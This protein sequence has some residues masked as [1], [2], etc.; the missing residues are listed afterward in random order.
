MARPQLPDWRARTLRW[1]VRAAWLPPVW[2]RLA[3][4]GAVV[5]GWIACA[6]WGAWL[7]GGAPGHGDAGQLRLLDLVYVPFTYLVPQTEYRFADRLLWQEAVARVLGAAVP[8]LGLF[9]LVRR[10]LLGAVAAMLGAGGARGYALVLGNAGS[11][12]A[13]AMATSQAG[14]PVLLCDPSIADD[15]DRQAAL[16]GAGVLTLAATGSCPGRAGSITAWFDADAANLAQALAWQHDPGLA[17]RDAL[18]AVHTPAA[19]RAM[20]AAP[21][22]AQRGPVRLRP[23][24]VEANAVRRSLATAD[25]VALA[26]AR[27]QSR[28]TLVLWGDG[29]SLDWA[30]ECALRQFWSIHLG[31]PA[32][33]WS[34]QGGSAALAGLERHAPGVFE[35]DWQ[36]QLHMDGDQPDATLHWVDFHSADTTIRT[37]F[38]LAARLAQAGSDPAPVQPVL[39]GGHAIEPLFAGGMLAFL[40]PVLPEADLTVEGL[41]SRALDEAAALLHLAYEQRHGGSGSDSAVTWQELPEIYVAANR[42][43]ADHVAVKRWDAARSALQGEAL[44]DALARVEHRRWC[45]ERLLSGWAPAGPPQPRDNARRL[46]PDLVPWSALSEAQ[47][48]KDREQVREATGL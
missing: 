25:P 27:G 26:V 1:L 20:L 2:Q 19:Q 46:H 37:A 24:S 18:F 13:L 43:A 6:V 39:R 48:E 38:E 34:G 21:L 35:P 9:W 31:P 30:A 16:G 40:P 44:V 45:A 47:R 36:P 12:D 22:L 8:L 42:A 32:V 29:P 4:T 7:R 41:R 17:G 14:E 15:E 3:L 33:V 10:R 23:V 28:V 11:A 5:I